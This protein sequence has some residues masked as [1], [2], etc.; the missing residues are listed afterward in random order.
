[1]N[2]TCFAALVCRMGEL[3]WQVELD[4][5]V[6]L[7]K[8]PRTTFKVAIYLQYQIPKHDSEFRLILVS[9]LCKS[10]FQYVWKVCN[11][12][13]C[14]FAAV[15]MWYGWTNI[16]KL[17]LDKYLLTLLDIY[18]ETSGQIFLDWLDKYFETFR[19]RRLT[20]WNH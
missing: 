17:S 7:P 16:L 20:G 10:K 19:C 12:F 1:M 15:R 5:T 13:A 11:F 2:L 14:F 8:V 4:Y 3:Y 9:P 18:L 6:G